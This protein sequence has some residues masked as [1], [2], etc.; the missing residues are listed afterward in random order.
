M[1]AK[2]NTGHVFR[3]ATVLAVALSVA[4]TPAAAEEA[5]IPVTGAP[6]ASMSSSLPRFL[7]DPGGVRAKLAT[8]GITYGA[9][10]IGEVLGVTSGG[11]KREA[12]YDGRLELYTNWDLE[13]LVGW[14]GATFFANAFQIHG[15][16]VAGEGVGSLAP[17]SFIEATPATRLFEMWLEQSFADDQVS[18]RI[19]QLAADSEFGNTEGGGAFINGTFGWTT[20]TASNMPDGGPAYPLA[21]PGARL[22][23]SL[24]EQVTFLAG[25]YN[26]VP[27]HPCTKG[28]PQRCNSD[29]LQFPLGDPP[30]FI[31]EGQFKYNIGLPGTLKLGGWEHFGS[32]DDTRF[33]ENRGRLALFGGT[34]LFHGTNYGLYA[35]IDQQIYA[36]KGSE[37]RG[38]AV[39]GRVMTNPGDRNLVSVYGEGGV[40]VTGFWDRRPDDI[41]VIGVAHTRIASG[42]RGADR[43]RNEVSGIAAPIRGIETILE[44]NYSAQIIPGWTV[45]PVVEHFWNPGGG[46]IDPDDDPAGTARPGHATVV[47]VR[48]TIKY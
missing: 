25:L 35:V 41:F 32:F 4:G 1:Q 40:T 31:A 34:P 39:F 29:G 36:V 22:K 24:S 48:T 43:D 10:Y 8:R 38:V 6:E 33:N 44:I 30:L 47:G 16:S 12:Q 28:D 42:A 15:N 9:N 17:V 21:T 27:A 5:G 18:L 26:G 45:Q 19:G 37:T 11:L 20:L 3:T 2:Q 46:G 14:R 7:A 13:K 23:L